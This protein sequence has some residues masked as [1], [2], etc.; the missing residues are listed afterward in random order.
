MEVN[1]LRKVYLRLKYVLKKP[2][3]VKDSLLKS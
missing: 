2:Y 3:L 1:L